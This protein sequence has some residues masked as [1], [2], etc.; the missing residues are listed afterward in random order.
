[1]ADRNYKKALRGQRR[2]LRVRGKIHGTAE[3]PRLTV[4]RTLKH[5]YAQIIDDV[6]GRTLAAAASNSPQVR[7]KL[8]DDAN[9]TKVAQTVGEA[10][11]EL[12]KQNGVQSVVFDRNRFPF[13]G[14]V[15]ALAEGARKGGLQF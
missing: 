4:C 6:E 15:K 12:A 11:A 13:H 1:M 10:L 14:R 7:E 5:I 2:R 3:R 8:K 9:K